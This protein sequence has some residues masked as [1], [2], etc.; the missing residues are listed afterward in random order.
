M[1]IRIISQC[2]PKCFKQPPGDGLN[3]SKAKIAI[4]TA[5]SAPA[6]IAAEVM[7][8]CRE[9]RGKFRKKSILSTI[10]RYSFL[11]RNTGDTNCFIVSISID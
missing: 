4:A 11:N 9:S 8:Q 6:S 10:A 3:R 5:L 2:R 7:S 1:I